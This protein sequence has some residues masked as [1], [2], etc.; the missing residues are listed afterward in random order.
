[1]NWDSVPA[2]WVP[3]LIFVAR[4]TDLTFGTLRILTV[5]RGRKSLAWF[6]ALCQATLFVTAI[7]GVL[8]DLG[9]VV[10]ILA[11]AG[12]FATGNVIGITLEAALAPGHS[13]IRIVSTGRHEAMLEALQGQGWGATELLGH[14]HEGTVGSILCIA[15]R[16]KVRSALDTAI[17]VD[18]HA[19]MTIENVREVRGG[20]RA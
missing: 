15:P 1:M 16:R 18:P 7:A 10:H 20:W 19:F 3:L 6:L 17:R 12:G 2:A 5:A 14:G 9:S 4:S 8:T 11:Y 13:L